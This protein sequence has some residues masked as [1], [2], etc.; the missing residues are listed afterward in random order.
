MRWGEIGAIKY[1][2]FNGNV[3]TK[4]VITQISKRQ[5]NRIASSPQ[6]QYLIKKASLDLKLAEADS[7][8]LVE[9]QRKTER[10]LRDQEI[11]QLKAVYLDNNPG[12]SRLPSDSASSE[13]VILVEAAHLLSDV[14]R[15]LSQIEQR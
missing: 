8:S 5:K 9:S 15:V 14:I 6:Y 11:E 2:T 1:Q 4:D 7:F 13:E 12:L 10:D 3:L